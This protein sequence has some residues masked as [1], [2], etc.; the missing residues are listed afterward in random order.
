LARAPSQVDHAEEALIALVGGRSLRAGDRLPPERE[1]VDV[2][3]ASRAAVREAINRLAAGGLLASR[4]GSGTYVAQVDVAAVTDVRVLLEP[5]AAARAA[6]ERTGDQ[7]AALQR[8]VEAM[9]RAVDD[10][11]AFAELDAEVHALVAEACG[12]PV[13]ADVLGRLA[14]AAALS[15][16]VTSTDAA[17]RATT[18]RELR[19]LVSAIAARRGDEARDAMRRH[20][21]RLPDGRA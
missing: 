6:V 12:N 9:A 18:L 1:L 7:L 8:A 11:R 5:E 14:R 2:L 21:E 16:A 17:I 20:L 15:R 19:S 10:S 3:G 4:Q 13:L